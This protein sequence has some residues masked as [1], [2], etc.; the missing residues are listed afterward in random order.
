M[1]GRV[2]PGVAKDVVEDLQMAIKG[3]V[4]KKASKNKQKPVLNYDD[5]RHDV[6][7]DEGF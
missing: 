6:P 2:V 7:A 4:T 3:I 1:L 5:G